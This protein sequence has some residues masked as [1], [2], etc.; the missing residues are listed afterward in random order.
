MEHMTT[1]AVIQ[2]VSGPVV[3]ARRQ[4]PL[5]VGEAVSVGPAGLLGE[6][7]KVA[8]LQIL[9]RRVCVAPV[10]GVAIRGPYLREIARN[11]TH[12]PPNIPHNR[13]PIRGGDVS[14]LHL[15]FTFLTWVRGRGRA[16][17]LVSRIII[18]CIVSC[19][20]EAMGRM[21]QRPRH[22][23]VVSMLEK[24]QVCDRIEEVVKGSLV[25][26]SPRA[27]SQPA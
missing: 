23:L 17:G 27:E 25:E 7:R 19:T 20:P 2:S 26:L 16:W 13:V 18:V 10:I 12:I 4:A 22:R 5:G 9:Q 6:G 1:A 21:L 15:R 11:I 3:K 8:T 14:V 24:P